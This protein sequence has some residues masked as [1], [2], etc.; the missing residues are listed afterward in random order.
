MKLSIFIKL[1]KIVYNTLQMYYDDGIFMQCIYFDH[2][3]IID[4]FKFIED[5]KVKIITKELIDNPDSLSLDN[6]KLYVNDTLHLL[7]QYIMYH[8]EMEVLALKAEESCI[9][10]LLVDKYTNQISEETKRLR[11]EVYENL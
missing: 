9:F 10:K 11:K 2:A 3:R 4:S 5:N 6:L 8:D 1:N 7:I